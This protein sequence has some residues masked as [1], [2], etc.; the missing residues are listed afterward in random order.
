MK[1]SRREF[2]AAG[3]AAAAGG[4]AANCMARS[5][6]AGTHVQLPDEDGYKLWLRYAQPGG[7][8][9][10]YRRV[11]RQLRVDGSSATCGIIRDELSSATTAMLGRRVP[12]D[13]GLGAGTVIV[14]TPAN[15]ALVRD[16][17]WTP[18]LRV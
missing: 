4:Y 12:L 3:L 13:G 8:L 6:A 1:I 14:G 9:R 2:V 10:Q 17:H 18:D 5:V 15:S 16:L 11:V 7:I